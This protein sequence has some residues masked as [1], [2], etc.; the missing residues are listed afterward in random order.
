MSEVISGGVR[1][2]PDVALLIRAT[3]FRVMP[4]EGGTS[5]TLRPTH[6][7]ASEAKQSI[8]PVR[9]DREPPSMGEAGG[10]M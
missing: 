9:D 3:G 7:I 2:V 1:V 8:A 4:R 10:D 5:S 6:V